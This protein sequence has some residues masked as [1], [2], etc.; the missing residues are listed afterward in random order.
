MVFVVGACVP[1]HSRKVTQHDVVMVGLRVQETFT[2]M[3]L[4]TTLD[5]CYQ[6]RTDC[7]SQ[8]GQGLRH[9]LHDVCR[10]WALCKVLGSEVKKPLAKLHRQGD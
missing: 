4:A 10:K 1:H 9:A 6:G 2:F 8:L 7:A 5:L 3:G